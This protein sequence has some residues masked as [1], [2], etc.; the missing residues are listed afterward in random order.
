MHKETWVVVCNKEKA[1]IFEVEKFG[2]LRE[3]YT[4]VHPQS[5]MKAEMLTRDGLGRTNEMFRSGHSTMD[6]TTPLKLKEAMNFA[7][8]VAKYLESQKNG[9]RYTR[10]FI[11]AEPSFLGILRDELNH[12]VVKCVEGEIPK[13]LTKLDAK[14]IWEHMPIA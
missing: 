13:D 3:I 2:N 14:A 9:M 7:K 10:M 1:R 6:P 5:A 11:M 4:M 12:N 8:E